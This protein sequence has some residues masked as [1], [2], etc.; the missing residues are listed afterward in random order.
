MKVLMVCL[1][2]IC[3]S[4]LA[5]GILE[6]K[7]EQQKLD[8]YIDS[9]GTSGWHQGEKPDARSIA[10]AAENGINIADQKSRLFVKEDFNNFDLI[11]A[12]DSSNYANIIRL[13]NDDADTSKVHLIMNFYEP[14][15]NI[16]VPDPY[17]DGNFDKVYQLL[18]NACTKIINTYINE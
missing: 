18:N 10:I 4:P 15:M 13:S 2:N 16:N 7:A 17:Y 3:R 5:Q 11:L 1:G 14:G 8:W 9:A 12:M 6:L